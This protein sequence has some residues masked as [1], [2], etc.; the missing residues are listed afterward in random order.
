MSTDSDIVH[1]YICI[2]FIFEKHNSNLHEMKML[3]T[4][5]FERHVVLSVT[6]V[7]TAAISTDSAL[8]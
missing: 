7:Y 6:N 8:G 2:F 1:I 4:H 3:E 5:R